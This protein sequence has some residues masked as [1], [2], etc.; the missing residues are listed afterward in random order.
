MYAE[1]APYISPYDFARYLVIMMYCIENGYSSVLESDKPVHI[2][3][4][5]VQNDAYV[6][7]DDGEL[8]T[9]KYLRTGD[10][11]SRVLEVWSRGFSTATCPLRPGHI[12]NIEYNPNKSGFKFEKFKTDDE[13][14]IS[15]LEEVEFSELTEEKIFQY[16]TV[17]SSVAA[18]MEIYSELHKSNI[19]IPLR[20]YTVNFINYLE[21]NKDKL[22][23]FAKEYME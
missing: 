11:S 9:R 18:A 5:C 10:A 8:E 22:D 16:S 6:S 15:L 17:D 2:D 21:H 14:E 20:V 3:G 13:N 19:K 7:D 23:S 1:G 12:F 4:Y